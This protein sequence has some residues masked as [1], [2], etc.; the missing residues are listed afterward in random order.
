MT[1]LFTTQLYLQMQKNLLVYYSDSI[2]FQDC[3]QSPYLACFF[4]L[5][6]ILFRYK[7]KENGSLLITLYTLI[8]NNMQRNHKKHTFSTLALDPIHPNYTKLRSRLLYIFA[9]AL[10]QLFC[11]FISVR[12]C[13]RW[14]MCQFFS[15]SI[16]FL[17]PLLHNIIA[18]HKP[19]REAQHGKMMQEATYT[20][21][22][23]CEWRMKMNDMM[24]QSCFNVWSPLAHIYNYVYNNKRFWQKAPIWVLHALSNGNHMITNQTEGN[25]INQ[26]CFKW[27]WLFFHIGIYPL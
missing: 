18:A 22:G 15:H 19:M 2:F 11:S 17:V 6:N 8:Q 14:I 3:C 7:I 21:R 25:T 13:G 27:Q 12:L 23:K 16:K 5:V 9:C 10:F 20:S 24:N 4:L 1:I 26:K